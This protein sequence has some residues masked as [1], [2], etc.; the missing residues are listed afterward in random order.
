MG[1]DP[2]KMQAMLYGMPIKS[3]ASFGGG[4]LDVDV[5]IKTF[6]QCL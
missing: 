2:E 1:F 6:A 4:E 3:L 5:L